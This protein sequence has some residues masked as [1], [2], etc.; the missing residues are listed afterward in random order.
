MPNSPE[1]LQTAVK[2]QDAEA[3]PDNC[4]IH[5]SEGMNDRIIGLYALGTCIRAL[6]VGLKRQLA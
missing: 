1:N 6:D 3:G 2:R 5:H 4:R